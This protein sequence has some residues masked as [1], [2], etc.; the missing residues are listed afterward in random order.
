MGLSCFQA[1]IWNHRRLSTT[2]L[3][4][5]SGTQ[6]PKGQKGHSSFGRLVE[7]H[8]ESGGLRSA[9]CGPSASMGEE[10]CF[11]QVSS[12]VLRDL[13]TIWVARVFSAQIGGFFVG[14]PF[15]KPT[16]KGIPQKSTHPHVSLPHVPNPEF[17][18]SQLALLAHGCSAGRGKGSREC[19]IRVRHG[20]QNIRRSRQW[21][22][23]KKA[24]SQIAWK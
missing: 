19:E 7:P 9:A 5:R 23:T 14:F 17:R 20:N 16:K 6:W 4:Q 12:R 21:L 1:G 15:I 2:Y 22:S 10:P 18:L 8:W 24:R 13:V 3:R 11:F